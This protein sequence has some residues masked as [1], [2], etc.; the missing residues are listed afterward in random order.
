MQT[1]N[2]DDIKDRIINTLYHYL[3]IDRI[4]I[5]EV[6][7]FM[8]YL[9]DLIDFKEIVF[10]IFE[11]EYNI[12][13]LYFNKNNSIMKYFDADN[14]MFELF[15]D[16]ENT[17]DNII[18]LHKTTIISN[19][20]DSSYAIGFHITN[21]IS[22]CYTLIKK[23][24]S[25]Y[26]LILSLINI[27]KLAYKALIE[28]SIYTDY[29]RT[30][31]QLADTLIYK[32]I[33]NIDQVVI[34]S[35]METNEIVYC[36]KYARQVY[37]NDLRGGKCY[38][39]F[40]NSDVQC[41]DCL[42]K[43]FNGIN[44]NKN[45]YNYKLEKYFD[46]SYNQIDLGNRKLIIETAVDVTDNRISELTMIEKLR[47]I[48]LQTKALD[49]ASIVTIR[50][51]NGKITYCNQKFCDTLG[52]TQDEA[53]GLQFLYT[54]RQMYHTFNSVANE[55]NQKNGVWRSEYRTNK[56]NGEII[57]LDTSIVLLETNGVKEYVAIS[58]DITSKIRSEEQVS[59]L[60]RAVQ[61]SPVSIVITDI[62]GNIEFVNPKFTEISD[63]TSEEVIGKNPKI[64]KSGYMSQIEYK[65][66]WD[67]IS[68][69]NT[70]VGYFHNKKKN[71]ELFWE[72][73]SIS[74]VYNNNGE[75]TNYIAIK[76]DVTFKKRIEEA[77]S[78]SLVLLQTTLESINEGVIAFNNSGVYTNIN[79]TF[80][81]LWGIIE[82]DIKNKSEIEIFELI[83][84][85]VTDENQIIDLKLN[86]FSNQDAVVYDRFYLNNELIFDV[87]IKPIR[88]QNA[89]T[90]RIWS[91]RDI[92]EKVKS[93][94]KLLYYTQSLEEAKHQLEEQTSKLELS[95]IELEKAK[96]T[97]EV[98]T[99]VKSEFIANISHEIRTPL[100]A[101][102]G[103]AELL[104][105]ENNPIKQDD[106]LNAI[107]TGGKNLLRLINDILD[108]SKIEAGRLDLKFESVNIRDVIK[109]VFDMF[110]EKTRKHRVDYS[111]LIADTVPSQIFI[112]EIRLRQ[113][114]FNLIGNA[115]KFTEKGKIEIIVNCEV[116][117]TDHQLIDLYIKVK[118][119]GIG[120]R[121]ELQSMIFDAFT[122]QTNNTTKKYEGTGLGLAITKKLTE[123]IGGS[124]RLESD[125]GVG[126][127]FIVVLNDLKISTE[128]DHSISLN[129]IFNDNSANIKDSIVIVADDIKVNR[130]LVEGF[131]IGTPIKIIEAKNGLEVIDL[132]D[133]YKPDLILMDLR[134]PEMTG[135]R[136]AEIIKNKPG[137]ETIPII[138]LTAVA[139]S[140]VNSEQN[141][142]N[143]DG[144]LSKPFTKKELMNIIEKYLAKDIN[145]ADNDRDDD[146]LSEAEIES[147]KAVIEILENEIM[148][149]WE[150]A[151]KYAIIDR[152]K[153]FAGQLNIIAKDNK[154][155]LLS[156]YSEKLYNQAQSFDFENLPYTL[157]LYPDILIKYKHN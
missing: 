121:K 128:S 28:K 45:I 19:L 103:F 8:M 96:T 109:E 78:N 120:I 11:N 64:L 107:M 116:N 1:R 40:Y 85:N 16:I 112:D 105:S 133:N 126:S 97:A 10:I 142:N 76:E 37:S 43:N 155:H 124:I 32:I 125:E 15:H 77:L 9:S 88:F 136:A 80:L 72:A 137:L 93:E 71:G 31:I 129:N 100:N 50:D 150:E 14:S 61:Y 23:D 84:D 82:D 152:I 98:A 138:A 33:D 46:I 153:E 2:K 17:E 130:K 106:Y 66:L 101:V 132:L 26:E 24:N 148:L 131:L 135:Y 25:D 139:F 146:H 79:N 36:N 56:K 4:S 38:K 18:R 70:W 92:T 75:I 69:G 115:V 62:K 113:I 74:P 99:K 39:F 5:K 143:F 94:K 86:V 47:K 59:I 44:I 29:I 52:Y 83:T 147:A 3:N 151:R 140:D 117:L 89:T 90:G 122:Q 51:E 157:S 21:S 68:S 134:M 20:F 123:M 111:V 114:L 67:T 95:I 41:K 110:T 102:I 156:D 91:F 118:D 48:D 119:T 54:D 108:L 42:R 154:L 149:K 53:A 73:A 87:S 12:R 49:L 34:V 141:L 6:N 7:D 104:K 35:D 65:N 22:K 145:I 27:L 81:Q 127:L 58:Y 30:D 60:S 55:L 57:W 63:Y 13:S 144:F